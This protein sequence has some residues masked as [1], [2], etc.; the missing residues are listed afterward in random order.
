MA[1]DLPTFGICRG[2]QVLNVAAGGGMIQH[3]DGHR[4]PTEKPLFHDV[5]I[6]E[7]SR[8]HR[9]VGTSKLPV[10]TYHHQGMDRASMASLFS[11][12]GLSAAPDGWLVEAFE[13]D[14]HRW[15][16]GVQWHPERLYEL[17]PAH[18]GL[19]DGFVAAC[20]E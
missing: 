1:A 13:S 14:S 5:L 2:C 20:E 4:S 17:P 15:L 11:V 9:M 18:K 19:W 6:E 16:V 7:N 8:V 3:F 12:V 10:N